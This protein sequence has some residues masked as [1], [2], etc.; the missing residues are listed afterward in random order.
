M[1]KEDGVKE[2]ENE[3]TELNGDL[4][5]AYASGYARGFRLGFDRGLFKGAVEASRMIL[6]V[7]RAK[8][9]AE[10]P[11]EGEEAQPCE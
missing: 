7:L 8:W 6:E 1:E 9:E 3:I 11:A 4:V 10:A 5:E 2:P